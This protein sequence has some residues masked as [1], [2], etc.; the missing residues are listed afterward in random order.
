MLEEG[1]SS[2]EAA[3]ALGVSHPTILEDLNVVE[4]L[5]ITKKSTT[6]RK[7]VGY[8]ITQYTKP[9]MAVGLSQNR[10]SEVLSE[11]R[12]ITPKADTP[13]KTVGYRITEYT[14]PA[15]AAASRDCSR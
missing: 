4:N 12:V 14:R 7:T 3:R 11:N 9:V 5:V 8:R 6:P 15:T 2:R 10:V 1:K 13:R